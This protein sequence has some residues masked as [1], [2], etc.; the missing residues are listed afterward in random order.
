M[1][2]HSEMS[3]T[4]LFRYII[5][6]SSGSCFYSLKSS[7]WVPIRCP[8][9]SSTWLKPNNTRCFLSSISQWYLY[10]QQQILSKK[11]GL[12][13]KRNHS[14]SHLWFTSK[15][16]LDPVLLIHG[17][18]TNYPKIQY[19]KTINTCCL[20]VFVAQKLRCY[21]NQWLCLRISYKATV[22]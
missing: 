13:E 3:F 22:K 1:G 17:Y 16:V 20:T 4:S 7:H 9:F 5:T 10:S 18:V 11:P 8:T 12:E 15:T 6:N 14:Q 21:L 2:R 19:L